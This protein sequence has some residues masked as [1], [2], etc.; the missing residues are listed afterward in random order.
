MRIEHPFDAIYDQESKVLI[1][2]SFPS[3]ISRN[4][5]FYYA[6]HNNR[7]W[8]VMESLFHEEICDR[9]E[10]CLRHHIALWDVIQSCEIE[11]SSD[12][13]I[14]NVKANDMNRVI[15]HTNISSIFLTGKK[16]L[17]LYERYIDLD[18]EYFG[19]PSTSSANA[20]YRL[21]DLV[22]AYA[23]ILEKL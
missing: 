15:E 22:E 13:S 2:G 9:K 4:E 17:S 5:N 7:F 21:N 18:I 14:R 1:L 8:Q 11:G 23:L 10:F 16:A 19:L 20:R 3:V 6:N 12:A